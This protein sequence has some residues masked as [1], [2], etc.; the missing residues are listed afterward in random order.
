VFHLTPSV[1]PGKS[2]L[3]QIIE[4]AGGIVEN[5]RRSLS[6]MKHQNKDSNLNKYLVIAVD[7][8][9]YLVKDLLA[10]KLPVF[11]A[12][13]VLGSILRQEVCTDLALY[14]QQ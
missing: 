3:K 2:F 1:V 8:D 7:Q 13:F 14:G 5:K 4:C 9:Q 12:E 10:E 11:T 6:F